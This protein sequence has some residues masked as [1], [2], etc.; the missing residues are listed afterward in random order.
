[1]IQIAQLGIDINKA[2]LIELI[3]LYCLINESPF[4]DP[5]EKKLIDLNESEAIFNGK[6]KDAAI[7]IENKSINMND[8][9]R[10]ICDDL[11]LLAEYLKNEDY[12]KAIRSHRTAV[13]ELQSDIINSSNLTFHEYGLELID[14]HSS[15]KNKFSSKNL[16]PYKS[17]ALESLEKLNNINYDEGINFDNFLIDFNSKL[18]N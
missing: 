9:K 1:L 11:Q 5:D 6:N 16:M 18:N 12:K 2:L 13:D 14:K 17:R 4:I 10:N 8:I 3:L 15:L 7:H